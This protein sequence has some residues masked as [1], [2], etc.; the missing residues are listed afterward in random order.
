MPQD[1][2]HKHLRRVLLKLMSLRKFGDLVKTLT[3]IYKIG[4]LHLV[5]QSGKFV[6][7]GIEEQ[8][9]DEFFEKW[10]KH[11]IQSE[12][13]RVRSAPQGKG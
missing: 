4:S 6:T 9:L 8:H 5:T 3:E 11:A 12:S 10:S 1:G 2:N 7:T 13:L